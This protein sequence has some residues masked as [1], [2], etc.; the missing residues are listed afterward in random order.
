M[1]SSFSA[2]GYLIRTRPHTWRIFQ[3]LHEYCGWVALRYTEVCG[4]TLLS[5]GDALGSAVG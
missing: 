5:S 3:L 1:T 2:A 4:L